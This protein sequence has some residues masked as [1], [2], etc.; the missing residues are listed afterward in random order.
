MSPALAL[1]GFLLLALGMAFGATALGLWPG[2]AALLSTGASYGIA[3]PLLICCA[4]ALL[5]DASRPARRR[6]GRLL[7]GFGLSLL[8][9]LPLVVL[10]TAGSAP[11]QSLVLMAPNSALGFL[12]VGV[13]LLVARLPHARWQRRVYLVCSNI[14]TLI[15]VSAL[16]GYFLNLE[17]LYRV[18]GMAS[19]RLP[20]ALALMLICMGLWLLYDRLSLA[21]Q[22]GAQA[23]RGRLFRRA[24]MVLSMVAAVA[25]VGGFSLL[26]GTLEDALADSMLVTA[27]TSAAAIRDSLHNKLW[28]PRIIASQPAVIRL[29][30]DSR[31]GVIS[32]AQQALI[33]ELLASFQTADIQ[34]VRLLDAR[35]TVIGERGRF[36]GESS[37]M[38]NRIAAEGLRAELRWMQGYLLHTEADVWAQGQLVGYAVTE[39][40]LGVVNQLLDALRASNESADALVCSQQATV[41][42]CAPTRF[43]AQPMNIPMRN[44]EGEP[45][46][47]INRALLGQIGVDTATDLR[48]VKVMAAYTPVPDTGLALVVKT[49]LNTLYAPLRDRLLVL[50]PLLLGAVAL[51]AW[52]LSV[53]VQP[54][55]DRFLREQQRN[56]LILEHSHDAFFSVGADGK[57]LDWNRAAQQLFGISAERAKGSALEDLLRLSDAQGSGDALGM[58]SLLAREGGLSEL[59]LAGPD[60]LAHPVEISVSRLAS[61]EGEQL[62]VFA[63]DLSARRQAERQLRDSEQSLRTITAT[64]PA[65][66]SRIDADGRILF[67]NE[68]CARVYGL[69]PEQVVG[70]TILDIRGPE[71]AAQLAPHVERVLQGEPVRFESHS[72][73]QGVLRHFQQ[74]Y[75]P[76]RAADGTVTGFYAVS[77]DITEIKGNEARLAQSE[78]W[79]RDITDNLPV[80]IAYIEPTQRVRFL[81]AT[82]RDWLGLGADALIGKQVPQLLG[83]GNLAATAGHLA[84]ALT[85]H[86]VRFEESIRV[87][88]ETRCLSTDF[89]PDQDLDG[90][91]SGIY[92]LSAD[93]TE[94]KATER[95][96]IELLDRD[97]LTGVANRRM[98][99]RCLPE[100]MAR[101]RRQRIGMALM[102]LDIDRFKVINDSHGHGVGDAVLIEFA[103]RL[104]RSVRQTDSVVR[105]AGDEF[106]LLLE[107]L[108]EAGE[109]GLVAEKVIAAMREPIAAEGLQLTISTSIG[110]AYLGAA[111]PAIGTDALIERADTALYEAKRAGRACYRVVELVEASA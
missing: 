16:V 10:L 104:T 23:H 66:I 109:A 42:F 89:V 40:R 6:I 72:A 56:R 38:V 2:L 41:A 19:M 90:Q 61:A 44:P 64:V 13:A 15:A 106:M 25:G 49:D 50:L 59:A 83:A 4:G 8:I 52:A 96:L 24:L 82:G 99:N 69:S 100:A 54:L 102:Y 98:L 57:V 75:V 73:V 21:W 63:R 22:S 31:E 48:G 88:G 47:P 34:A 36:E 79:L 65:L 17:S 71:A 53:R 39:Q 46:L 51:G 14:A 28:Y 78:R 87:H 37:A 3:V 67:A 62:F 93:V 92:A 101:V 43:Y 1:L 95:Q 84:Q 58:P 97:T 85:G 81:N 5:I 111:A 68:H 35:R 110:V 74:S 18:A 30:A 80:L 70:R 11:L 45:N 94:L 9:G 32:A 107:G 103:A 7:G 77:V 105:L 26:R 55:L 29:M 108:H 86:R 20:T 60:G 33:A 27:R 91:I 76:D 12:L